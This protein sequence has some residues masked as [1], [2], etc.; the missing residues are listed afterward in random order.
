MEAA[1]VEL[2]D[3]WRATKSALSTKTFSSANQWCSVA[4]FRMALKSAS[5]CGGSE[6]GGAI[7][8]LRAISATLR[9][10]PVSALRLCSRSE[11]LGASSGSMRRKLCT[12]LAMIRRLFSEHVGDIICSRSLLSQ[13]GMPADKE[14]RR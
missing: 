8:S 7:L 6:A 9:P 4:L 10:R 2:T 13:N 11:V 5:D 1:R 14:E 12:S 3:R